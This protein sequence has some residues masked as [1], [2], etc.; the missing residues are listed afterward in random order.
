[1][2]LDGRVALVTGG[3]TGLGRATSL[4]LARAGVSVAVNY[5]R[6]CPEAE[7]VARQISD[8]GGTALAVRADITD[9]S[10][11]SSMVASVEAELGPVS[12]L[13][14]N[15]GTTRYVPFPDL[16]A[17]TAEEWRRIMDVNVTGAFLCSR[18]VAPGMRSRGAGKIINV[19]SNSAFTSAG[20]SIPYVVSKAALVSLTRCLARALA[21]EVQ[22]NAIAPGW[23]LTEW[24]DRHVP[25]DRARELRSGAVPVIPV[26]D[27]VRS[28]VGLLANDS[29]TGEVAVVDRGEM[30]G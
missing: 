20:S 7:R 28:L 29:I 2:D 22:V 14:N 21:P 16:G 12:I 23:M 27:V 19:A 9:D 17:V 6:S 10:A 18:A 13:V 30:L 11:V 5:S 24:I 26:E 8:H 15:A 1:M 3:G 4:E 25:P